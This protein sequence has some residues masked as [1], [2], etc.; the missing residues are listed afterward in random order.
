MH[1]STL[2]PQLPGCVSDVCDMPPLNPEPT[3]GYPPTVLTLYFQG[4]IEETAARNLYPP[5]MNIKAVAE[6]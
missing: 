5:G 1:I 4:N 3:A 6:F 2:R